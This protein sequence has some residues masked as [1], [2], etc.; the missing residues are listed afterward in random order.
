[1]QV[2][3]SRARLRSAVHRSWG[4]F[5]T[6]RVGIVGYYGQSGTSLNL[7]PYSPAFFHK[8]STRFFTSP[9]ISITPGQ[10][11]VKPSLGHLRVASIPIFDPK[12]ARRLAWS[13]E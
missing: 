7:T 6:Y 2:R 5:S 9:L 4:T 10:G 12:F 11:R 3:F 8:S 13:S 1:M